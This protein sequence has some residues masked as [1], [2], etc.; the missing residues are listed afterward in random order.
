M[1]GTGIF[2]GLMASRLIASCFLICVAIQTVFAHSFR[3]NQATV[4]INEY[5]AFTLRSG[6]DGLTPAQRASAIAASLVK[7]GM[8][9]PIKAVQRKEDWV[10]YGGTVRIVRITKAEAAQW[11]VSQ[12]DLAAKW[13]SEIQ[14]AARLPSIHLPETEVK[15]PAGMTRKILLQGA[16]AP[17]AQIEFDANSGLNV[18]RTSDGVEVS[19]D[20]EGSYKLAFR[21]GPAQLDLKVVVTAAGLKLPSLISGEVM[22]NPASA[23]EVHEATISAI[24]EYFTAHPNWKVEV[25]RTNSS[26]LKMGDRRIFPAL[27]RL[28]GPQGESTQSIINIEIVNTG[29]VLKR[30]SELWYSNFPENVKRPATLYNRSLKSGQ[31]V[32]VLYHHANGTS[33]PMTLQLGAYNLSSRPAQM[34]VIVGDGTPDPDPV[35]VGLDAGDLFIRA[36]LTKQAEIISVPPRSFVPFA[37]RRLNPGETMSGIAYLS[38]ASTG[39]QR[40]LI[41]TEAHQGG[42]DGGNSIASIA[43][44]AVQF[45]PRPFT[46]NPKDEPESDF[47]FREP[48]KAI[49]VAYQVDGKH[50]H[51]RIGEKSIGNENG[52]RFLDG[53]YGVLY[54][55]NAELFNPTSKPATVNVEFEASAGYSGCIFAVDNQFKRLPVVQTKE[56]VLIE[57]FRLAPGERRMVKLRTMPLGGSSYP[58][59]LTIRPG[60]QSLLT[61]NNLSKPGKS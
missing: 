29:L 8:P 5:P 4:Y 20:K 26:V 55:V 19:A 58:A 31:T 49:D 9:D 6:L 28:R 13:K 14:K 56:V 27:V 44:A 15:V 32:R 41:R 1:E 52:T 34:V 48:Y 37:L 22:G 39:P 12:V 46:I 47:V 21:L 59:T 16:S 17:R 25:L 45:P 42:N 43:G 60:S 38:F 30:E 36:L 61:P 10:L 53:N 11:G 2:R 33:D 7:D 54:T 35:R 57:S 51:V 50:Q 23:S 40:L 18:K 3:S 24:Q